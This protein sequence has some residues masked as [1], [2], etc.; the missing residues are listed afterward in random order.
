MD[1][2]RNMPWNGF[3][4]AST[5][6][7]AGGSSLGYRMAG[8]R[9]LY[10]SEF[11]D[12]AADV[13][14]LNKAPYTVVD[15]RDIR[16]VHGQ[17]ILDMAGVEEIDL[18]D[19]S[20]PCDS[21]STAGARERLWGKVKKYADREQRSDDLS[22][23]FAR[24]LGE[25]QPKTFVVE[26]VSGL[27]KGTAKGYFKRILNALSDQGYRVKA[28]LLDASWLGVPQARQRII[29]IGVRNDLETDPVYPTPL[30]WQY[31]LRDA[32][33][34]LNSK[35]A[36]RLKARVIH[37]TAGQFSNGD[38]TNGPCST[39]TTTP[40]H[41][42]VERESDMTMHATGK[43]WKKLSVGS[44]SDKYFQLVRSDPKQPVGTVTAS[45]GNAGLASVSHPFECRKFS[46]AE[47][48]RLCSFPDDFK[49]SGSYANQWTRLGM[50]VPPVIMREVA[51]AVYNE[52]LLKQRGRHGRATG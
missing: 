43:E 34:W 46:I 28:R 47:L 11:V 37:D 52:I 35:E 51:D 17:E 4:V 39:I 48:K 2:I 18:F 30:S 1:E 16:E 6:S 41:F 12:A 19:G 42:R 50:A 40:A 23:E 33:P 25:L 13:Y 29:F 24:I 32:I 21:F 31:T 49:L 36:R 5:F 3:T 9:V 14:E 8:F 20:P 15:R 44:Q 26:N 10:A 27:V 45:G 38:I 22:F 7:G